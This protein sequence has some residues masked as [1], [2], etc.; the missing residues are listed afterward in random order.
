M[1]EFWYS[2]AEKQLSYSMHNSILPYVSVD[3]LLNFNAFSMSTAIEEMHH[4]WVP[5]VI[6]YIYAYLWLFGRHT[7]VQAAIPTAA[8]PTKCFWKGATNTNSNPNPYPNPNPYIT[9]LEMLE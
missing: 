6:I 3:L 4:R 8:I 5:A 1:N 7:W 2:D 9:H